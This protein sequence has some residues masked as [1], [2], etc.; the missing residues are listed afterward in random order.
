[1]RRLRALFLVT[2]FVFQAVC[3][4]PKA[5]VKLK[6][7]VI[8]GS[9]DVKPVARQEFIITSDDIVKLWFAAKAKNVQSTDSIE[10]ELRAEIG[11][12]KKQAELQAN[13]T[14]KSIEGFVPP[15]P[16]DPEAWLIIRDVNKLLQY[17]DLVPLVLLDIVP[18]S[19]V[20]QV[21]NEIK[22]ITDKYRPVH[23]FVEA[24]GAG[25]ATDN[26]V[27]E[28]MKK[29]SE[30]ENEIWSQILNKWSGISPRIIAVESKNNRYRAQIQGLSE[31][32]TSLESELKSKSGVRAEAQKNGDR[33]T[34]KRS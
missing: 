29:S 30:K 9:G 28:I 8:M 18:E 27:R 21:E 3:D 10:T 16:N 20:D 4:P 26:F 17:L 6:V 23:T 11:Y 13:I 34:D 2:L 14:K 32:I 24:R 25:R 31:S 22:P 33:T 7:G 1:M 5:I 12:E 15:D 19:R